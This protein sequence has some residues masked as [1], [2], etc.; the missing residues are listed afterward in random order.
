MRRTV[1]KNPSGVRVAV[2]VPTYKDRLSRL[3]TARVRMSLSNS[4]HLDSY[5]VAPRGLDTT[6]Y[7]DGW[8]EVEVVRF[9]R[10]HFRSVATYNRWVLR[11]DLYRRFSAYEFILICQ[12][13]AILYR[14]LPVQERWDFDY[15]GAPWV[16][17][18][19]VGWDDANRRLKGRGSTDKRLL[20][21]G[22]GGL[23]LRRTAVFSQRL[24]LPPFRDDPQEDKAISYFADA[25]G[26]RVAGV[27]LAA[28]LFMETGAL[29]WR[30]GDPIPDAHGFHGLER[31][32]P[33][34]ERAL[35]GPV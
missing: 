22:N 33:E 23:S 26:V 6:R 3:E 2:I 7:H 29:G 21:V 28:G 12:T 31:Q 9:A 15:L 34:L 4:A 16:P 13:D 30:P 8:P 10:R 1:V 5:F 27:A 11:P 17:P 20:H 25:I 19:L 35:L 24:D 32:N 18:K 14:P